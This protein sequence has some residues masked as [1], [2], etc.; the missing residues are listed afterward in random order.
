MYN[1]N[2]GARTE[3]CGTP[4]LIPSG[5]EDSPLIET[6]FTITQVHLEPM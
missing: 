1:K 2:S 3:P 4:Q 6:M 5:S